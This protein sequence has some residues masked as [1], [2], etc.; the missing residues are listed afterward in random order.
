MIEWM[1][2]EQK[3]GWEI[4]YKLYLKFKEEVEN[5]GV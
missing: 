2:K 3:I 5:W 1:N 4:R